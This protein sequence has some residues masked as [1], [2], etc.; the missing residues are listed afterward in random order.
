MTNSS[1]ARVVVCGPA[2][3]NHL[4]YLERLPEPVP[5]MQ[6][7]LREA[8]CLGGTS[9]G[10]AVHLTSLGVS[11][12][13]HALFA[14]DEEGRRARSALVGAGVRLVSHLSAHTERHVNLMTEAGERVSLYLATPS[15]AP[16]EAIE[17]IERS[18]D[19]AD[20][21]VVDLSEVGAAL[22]GRRLAGGR[23]SPPLWTDLHDYDG[24]S[25]FH[26]PFVQAAD[27]VFMND[28][29]TEDPWEVMQGC[30]ERGPSLAV[31]TLG[32]RGAIALD[33]RG[34]RAE[35]KALPAAVIDTNGAGDAFFAGFL[36]ASLQ[37]AGMEAKLAAGARQA[38][39]ALSTVNLHPALE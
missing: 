19:S 23:H 14:A 35:V 3:W 32:S 10:K 37:G 36:A 6:F 21:A 1:L 22:V 9:A 27:V 33:W 5:H 34:N 24:T 16:I 39:V 25:A 13:L 28:D 7:A 31:C 38:V 15:A 26:D 29:R 8:H 20:V 4:I 2:T 12:T 11:T 17:D 30:L 18:L